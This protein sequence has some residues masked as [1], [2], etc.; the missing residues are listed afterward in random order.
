MGIL[1]LVLGSNRKQLPAFVT[2]AVKSELR[3]RE[4]ISMLSPQDNYIVWMGGVAGSGVAITPKIAFTIVTFFRAV[5][6]ICESLA[7]LPIPLAAE[8][9]NGSDPYGQKLTA[10]RLLNRRAN[11]ETTAFDY[12]SR[13]WVDI[14]QYGNHYSQKLY[15]AFDEVIELWPLDAARVRPRREKGE[16]VYGYTKDDGTQTTFSARDIMHVKGISTDS[17]VGIS[18]VQAAATSLGLNI[19]L[20]ACSSNLFKNGAK[21]SGILTMP[22]QLKDRERAKQ[23]S[24]EWRELVSG[25]DN[26][27]KPIVLEQDMKWQPLSQTMLDSQTLE[28]RNF[29]KLEV[30]TLTGVPPIK[31]GITDTAT[32]GSTEQQMLAFIVDCLQTKAT[33]LEQV[34]WNDL[35]TLTEQ[36]KYFPKHNFKALLRGDSKTR[37]EVYALGRNGGWLSA[38]DVRDLEDMPRLPDNAGQVYLAPVNMMDA[39]IVSK[40]WST[41]IDQ[42]ELQ[43]DQLKIQQEAPKIDPASVNDPGDTVNDEAESVNDK[44]SSVNDDPQI[45][46][47]SRSEMNE[48]RTDPA[49]FDSLFTRD[50]GAEIKVAFAAAILSISERSVR[51]EAKQLQTVLK[52]AALK[53]SI[54]QFRAKVEEVSA[55]FEAQIIEELSPICQGI[56]A[57]WGKNEPKMFEKLQENLRNFCKSNAQEA[58][59]KLILQDFSNESEVFVKLGKVIESWA[60]TRANALTTGVLESLSHSL[61]GFAV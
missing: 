48:T 44:A 41:R 28:Q 9:K 38:D 1:S 57:F 25:I 4:K 43:V 3:A 47:K 19:A 56:S 42:M 7:M 58:R 35:L 16:L 13:L 32:Y 52:Q 29:Q 45:V 36:K 55:G 6:I 15:N 12:K 53:G 34:V 22:G 8:D 51:K 60:T 61:E 23:M 54:E 37:N 20:E 50:L 49:D 24:E 31:L 14:M 17:I 10:Y 30:A 27:G 33:N 59:N 2:P 11:P 21:P 18:P 39:K 40:F 5:Q 46:N 26:Y